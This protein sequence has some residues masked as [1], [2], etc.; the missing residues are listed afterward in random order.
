MAHR[1]FVSPNCISGSHV[2]LQHDVAHQISTVL[3]MRPGAEIELL[4]DS[5]QVYQVRL[6]TVNKDKITGQVISRRK[7]SSEPTVQLTL[8]QATLKAQKFEWVIQKATELGVTHFVPTIFQRSVVRDRTA[9]LKKQAR[10]MAVIREA[11]EQSGRGKLPTLS[12]PQALPDALQTITDHTL[13][14]MPGSRSSKIRLNSALV[15]PAKQLNIGLFIGPEGGITAT[16]AHQASQAGV[17]LITLG[18]RILR[19]ET[20]GLALVATVLYALDEWESPPALS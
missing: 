6:A 2:A 15:H 5:G 8:Y 16:E 18:P 19:A 11:A 9:I 1:F 14:L 10:W 17:R 3:R 20:A 13:T 7:T 12:G 4:D